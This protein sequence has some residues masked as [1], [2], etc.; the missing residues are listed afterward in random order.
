MTG[1]NHKEPSRLENKLT[2]YFDDFLN[3]VGLSRTH[4][5]HGGF[6]LRSTGDAADGKQ[7]TWT[8][9]ID[10]RENDKEY[11]VIADVPGVGKEDLDVEFHDTLLVISGQNKQDPHNAPNTQ[12]GVD[13]DNQ[14]ST[15]PH[16]QQQSTGSH[17]QQQSTGRQPLEPQQNQDRKD[18]QPEHQPYY[19]SQPGEQQH[20]QQQSSEQGYQQQPDERRYQQQPD[21]QR[22]QQQPDE[23]RYQ[24]QPDEQRYQQQPDEQR[25][26]QQAGQQRRHP[27]ETQNYQH[28]PKFRQRTQGERIHVQE[29]PY[30]YFSRSIQLPNNIKSDDDFYANLSNGVLK[31]KIPKSNDR[32]RK[33]IT[34]S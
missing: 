14:Q 9:S 27:D 4:G 30:G 32:P 6:K 15:G 5:T 16:H 20:Y 23:Q 13:K 10:I 34:I 12:I 33:K 31:I 8:P 25:Y 29:R 28:L 22:Y 24:Q 7:P 18:K 26:Q 1:P 17:H 2:R 3:D 21:E 19:P 11:I